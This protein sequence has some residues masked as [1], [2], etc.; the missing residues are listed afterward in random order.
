M[1]IFHL[2]LLG[3]CL[4][5]FT[6]LAT[7]DLTLPGPQTDECEHA[8][9]AI[10]LLRPKF[11]FSQ[12]YSLRI[13]NQPFPFGTSPHSGALKAYLLWPLFALF[14]PSVEVMRLFTIFLGLLT[15]VF[16]YLF[17][18]ELFGFWPAFWTTLLL[19]LDSSF[20][21]YSKLDAGPIMDQLVWVTF[22]FWNFAKWRKTQRSIFL[23]LSLLSGLFGIYSHIAFIW[24]LFAS[25][26]ALWSVAPGELKKCLRRPLFPWVIRLFL[27]SSA[28][29]LYWLVGQYRTTPDLHF[30]MAG[31][32]SILLMFKRLTT[33][34]GIVPE[35]LT[36]RRLESFQPIFH[37]RPLTDI[38]LIGSILF[39]L[40]YDKTKRMRCLMFFLVIGM[41]AMVLTPAQLS[42]YP[43][44]M[45]LFYIFL[46]LLAGV[47]VSKSLTTLRRF[48]HSSAGEWVIASAVALL[49]CV[50][51]VGQSLLVREV[52][53]EIRKTGGRGVWSDAIYGLSDYLKKGKWDE[54]VCL[55]WEFK[56]VLF[57]LT[58][59][60][61]LF[62]EI[63]D[64]EAFERR[65]KRVENAG[66]LFLLYSE[67][68]FWYGVL[69]SEFEEVV[70]GRGQELILERPFHQRDQQTVY[71]L[72]RIGAT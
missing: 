3:L 60:E 24:V 41:I 16:F 39:L 47:A 43:H 48:R 35:V 42:L 14:G 58:K 62:Q 68:Y 38:F 53:H 44:R 56:R 65:E 20:I 19:S 22:G 71:L 45:M 66:S 6:S 46:I 21:F 61:M 69:V 28:I 50:S 2:F 52:I 34:A 7:T 1:K 27:F 18:K 4:L 31:F 40:R 51:L 5:L 12:E 72:Y 37:I 11:P 8:V 25:P 17:A 33:Q 13:G 23:I 10:D 63:G 55:D 30:K 49:F 57:L 29:F 54:V 26:L 15:L 67:P 36:G 9:L 70:R 32:S 64:I 59:G